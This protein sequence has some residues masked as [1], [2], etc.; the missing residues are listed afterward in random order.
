MSCTVIA[1][2]YALAWVVGA[3][4]AGAAATA[5]SARRADA[6]T[7]YEPENLSNNLNKILSDYEEAQTLSAKHFIEKDFETAF[8][9][10]NILVKTL[11]EHGVKNIQEDFSER[12]SGKID[13]FSLVFTKNEGGK[14]YTL[15]ISCLET[16]S[17]EEKLGD[18]S[19]EYALNVQEE[20]YLSI[21]EKL[22]NNNMEIESEEVTEDNTIVLTVNIN[23]E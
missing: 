17:A 8:T 22:K 2:P 5:A 14:P 13:N 21:I 1:I 19:S 12:I 6:G 4:T 9:D 15:R 10:K 18:I 11:E 23:I 7:S 3:L 20:A 16:D